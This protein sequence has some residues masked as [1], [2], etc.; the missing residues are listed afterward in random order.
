MMKLISLMVSALMLLAFVSCSSVPN[1]S[2]ASIQAPD[3][4]DWE[5]STKGRLK[6]TLD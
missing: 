1:R 4:V 6:K 2:A 5:Q 3:S